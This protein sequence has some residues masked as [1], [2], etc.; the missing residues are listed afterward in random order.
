VVRGKWILSN[1]LGTPPP[2]P[3]PN[4][5]ALKENAAGGKL[6]SVRERLEEHRAN[7]VCASCHN[8]MDPLGFAME[9]FD[10]IGQ[11]RTQDSGAAIDSSATLATGQKVNGVVDLRNQIL[12]RPEQFV[13]TLTEKLL[14]YS[15][16]RGLDY[17]DAPTVRAITRNAAKQNYKITSLVLGIVNSAPF[18]MRT[19]RAAEVT[20][21]AQL[22]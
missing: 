8:V 3:P 20:A 15:L 7:P 17:N 22:N 2:S 18:Q 11:W 12:A 21:T 1:L 5:P 10:A 9:N 19:K 6:R 4:V 16:G 14:I 13:G